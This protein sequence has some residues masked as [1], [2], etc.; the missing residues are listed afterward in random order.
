MMKWVAFLLLFHAGIA[1][2]DDFGVYMSTRTRIGMNYT[3][4][5]GDQYKSLGNNATGYG[6]EISVLKGIW[7]MGS[8]VGKVRA[9]YISGTADF[10][11]GTTADNGTP[12]T[13]FAGEP[14]LGLEIN[15]MPFHPPGFRTY[16]SGMGVMSYDILR[17]SNSATFTTL[18][19]SQTA[20]GFGYELGA[21]VE[22]TFKRVDG[23]FLL[24]SEVQ[25]RSVTA[26]LAGQ[27]NF[28]LSGLQLAGGIGW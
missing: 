9:L 17:F 5:G 10:M 23:Q 21:G 19:K 13:L 25:Y 4:F 2:A 20:L 27:S 8:F 28:A 14:C 12:F 3:V 18:D 24:Y 26:K 15:L 11:D 22:V 1:S 6:G 16:I 7:S